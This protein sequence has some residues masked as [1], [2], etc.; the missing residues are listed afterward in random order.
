MT[1]SDR[2]AVMNA[3]GIEQIGSPEEIYDRPTNT[4]VAEF[5]G[6][7]QMNFLDGSV[8]SLDGTS[9]TVTVGDVTLEFDSEPFDGFQG[10]SN[11]TLGFRPE[12]VV[13]SGNG[14]SSYFDVD[15]QLLEPLGSVT[16][17]SLDGPQ[18]EIRATLSDSAHVAEGQRMNLTVDEG[19]IH[20]FDG[21]SGD[22]V[23]K[24]VSS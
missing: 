12:D 11:V 19:N 20:V 6:S 22:L 3:G 9:W 23:T 7:P 17:A 21:A 2:V 14:E 13:L 10:D 5:I 15:V 4:F 18:G 16:L 24:S 1:M 8:E